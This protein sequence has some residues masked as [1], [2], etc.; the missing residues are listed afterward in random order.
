MTA[1]W[2]LVTASLTACKCTGGRTVHAPF[3]SANEL[4]VRWG[5]RAKGGEGAAA[6]GETTAE[7]VLTALQVQG[8]FSQ[9]PYRVWA[10]HE[11]DVLDLCWS[12]TQVGGGGR[13]R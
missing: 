12:A 4:P 9:E 5:R 6:K 11:A 3:G 10:A 2:W 1:R 7:E 8:V 13:R